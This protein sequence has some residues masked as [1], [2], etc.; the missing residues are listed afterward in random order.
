RKRIA[1]MGESAGGGHAALV[2]LTARDRGEVPVLFQALIY[3]MLDDRTG[4]TRIVPPH[5]GKLVWTVEANRF[6]WRS[7]L[8]T[9]PGG[10]DVPAAAVPARATRLDGL[11][12]A[13]IRPR[14][15]HLSLP[16][17]TQH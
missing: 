3:P 4:S 8:G 7:F 15:I 6:G 10:A 14:S 5:I 9:D 17:A 12:P 13:F 11:P 16:H 2:A 1:V